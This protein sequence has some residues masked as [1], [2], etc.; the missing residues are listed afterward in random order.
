L[1]ETIELIENYYIL[2]DMEG[3][4][5]T[6]NNP[7]T[8]I[9]TLSKLVGNENFYVNYNRYLS[10]AQLRQDLYLV[11]K[12]KDLCWKNEKITRFLDP[13]AIRGEYHHGNQ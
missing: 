13:Q 4:K 3:R 10:E 7:R 2:I 5:M 8:I 9:K 12:L 11:K 6:E 1:I